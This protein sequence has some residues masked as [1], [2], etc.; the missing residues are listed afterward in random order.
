M[1]PAV[2]PLSSDFS[3]P[4]KKSKG[5]QTLF[6]NF[7]RKSVLCQLMANQG[8]VGGSENSTFGRDSFA[9]VVVRSSVSNS[10]RDEKVPE[11]KN[12]FP[13]EIVSYC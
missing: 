8:G 5:T 12:T 9:G 10:A 1:G 11:H 13:A 3:V 4:R 7:T 6:Y 2:L